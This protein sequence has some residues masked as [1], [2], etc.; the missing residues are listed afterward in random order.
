M[1]GPIPDGPVLIPGAGTRK[2]SNA[3]SPQRG[4]SMAAQAN[5][6]GFVTQ[7]SEQPQGGGPVDDERTSALFGNDC[8]SA[9]SIMSEEKSRLW[10]PRW[11]SG[12][13]W[14]RFPGRWPGLT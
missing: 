6:L 2:N 14:W 12:C 8:P 3:I 7:L 11:G 9:V 10:P 4:S 13:A 5:S 1:A